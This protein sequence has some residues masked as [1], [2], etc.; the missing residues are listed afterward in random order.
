MLIKTTILIRILLITSLIHMAACTSPAY[1][2]QAAR[3]HLQIMQQR[4]SIDMLAKTATDETSKNLFKQLIEIRE[5]ATNE[6]LLPDNQS[7]KTYVE[8]E[9]DYVTWVVFAARPF[10]LQPKL[11][12]FWV[13]GC[14][15]Y[16]GYFEKSHAVNFSSKLKQ[17]GYEVYVAPVPA[18]S[19]LGWFKDPVLS[20]MVSGN[21]VSMAE[22]IFHE[23]A[24]QK[25]YIK[26]DTALNEAFATALAQLGT[27]RW[28]RMSNQTELLSAYQHN[29][30]YL[31]QFYQVIS[32]LRTRL[33][34]IYQ[35]SQDHYNKQ[36]QKQHALKHYHTEMTTLL[37]SAQ[38]YDQYGSWF[39]ED[40]NNARLNAFA[41]YQN[42]VPQFINLF[43]NCDKKLANFYRSVEGLRGLKMQ[44]RRTQ[45]ENS[46]CR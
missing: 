28:L 12:C 6:L 46:L 2:L 43:H 40:V 36:Q 34:T 22:H 26:N 21:N 8:L 3:G 42:L 31:R 38:L 37:Q 33:R 13:A 29:N 15:P 4:E 35:S 32:D 18:Y 44:Q 25:L 27:E 39:L 45:L 17:Q 41:T 16:R 23:L 20:S 24:H 30:L 11:W 9:R 5:F 1:W 10:S 14:V 19:T 7:Y